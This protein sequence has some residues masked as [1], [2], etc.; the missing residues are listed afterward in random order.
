MELSFGNFSVYDPSK[1]SKGRVSM[2]LWGAAG[3]GKTTLAATAPG[4][5]LFLNLD[6]DGPASLA[7]VSGVTVIDLSREPDNIVD[8]LKM[9]NPIG[10]SK[11]LK[12]NEEIQ[13]I[14]VDSLTSHVAKG[15]NHAV[16]SGKAGKGATI[17]NP[18]LKGYQHRNS[19]TLQMVKNLLTLTGKLKRNVVFIAHEAAPD[20]DSEGVIRQI[21][22]ALGGQMPTSAP[23]DFSEVWGMWDINSKRMI[24]IR[25][26]HLR[27]PMKSRMF[28]T[29]G[30]PEFEWKYDADKQT[31]ARL[32]DWIN[33]WRESAGKIALP[34]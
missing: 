31:G 6:D 24:A 20:K 11:L 16:N 29:T 32:E 27:K 12:E 21:S 9:E 10:I 14:V 2:L 1:Q 30:K 23:R 7:G 3:C 26:C 33:K 13:T 34:T 25:P 18:S 5:V 19:Y 15:T 17:E 22:I 28:V 8:R 4:E